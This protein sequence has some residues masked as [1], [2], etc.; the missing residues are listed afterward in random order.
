[1]RD[2]AAATEAKET[3]VIDVSLKERSYQIV[4]G[5]H[6]IGS[7]GPRIAAAVPGARCVVVS[8]ANIAALYLEPLAE[9]ELGGKIYIDQARCARRA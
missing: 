8:D 2:R 5:E 7:A 9:S 3:T 6:L 1:M 4:V